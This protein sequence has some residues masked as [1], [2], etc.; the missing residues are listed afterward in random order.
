[1]VYI[2]WNLSPRLIARCQKIHSLRVQGKTFVK[3]SKQ[4][5]VGRAYTISLHS[6][7]LKDQKGGEQHGESSA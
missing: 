7:W 5:G 4:I 2:D 6:K 1:M 3:I